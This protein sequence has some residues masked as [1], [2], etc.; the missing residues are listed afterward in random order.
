MVLVWIVPRPDG[1][2]VKMLKPAT[3]D[4]G[5]LFHVCGFLPAVREDDQN[6]D[7]SYT[8]YHAYPRDM[9]SAAKVHKKLLISWPLNG[10][11]GF[12]VGFRNGWYSVWKRVGQIKQRSQQQRTHDRELPA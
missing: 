6:K 9:K 5:R 12:E 7:T 3:G 1:E 11:N 8:D 4:R 2:I 10:K